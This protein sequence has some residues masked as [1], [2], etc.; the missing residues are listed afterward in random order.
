[1][2]VLF[3]IAHLP[4]LKVLLGNIPP[5]MLV[6]TL[7]LNAP[8]GLVCGWLFWAHGIEAA[9]LAHFSADLVYHAIGTEALLRT[10]DTDVN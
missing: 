3:G 9:M 7:L 8:V 1:M 2:A 5:P 10:L 6:R 4:A